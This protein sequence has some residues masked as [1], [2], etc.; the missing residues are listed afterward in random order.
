MSGRGQGTVTVSPRTF[1][2]TAFARL[3]AALSP[4]TARLDREWVLA[5]LA[6]GL[7]IRMLRPPQRG[8]VM[9]QPESLSWRPILGADRALFVQDLRVAEGPDAREGAA[10]LWAAAA[11]FASYYGFSSVL[12]LIGPGC[13]IIAPAHAPGR[14]WLTLDTRADGIRLV[15]R[16][17]QGP[18]SLPRLP[19]DWA[20]RAEALGPDVV[21]QTTGQIAGADAWA[22][23]LVADLQAH[24]LAARHDRLATAHQARHR[25]VHP[26]AVCSVVADGVWLGGREITAAVIRA[27]MAG[28]PAAP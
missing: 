8:L 20:R 27:K 25:A 23:A 19:D 17:L 21:V 26:G 6:E 2:R 1:E 10:C 22:E 5:R 16:I 15:G 24:G 13:G 14:G 11:D 18:L 3:D 7:Q 4:P 28:G 12:A 9:F